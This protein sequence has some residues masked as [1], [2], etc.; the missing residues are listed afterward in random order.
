MVSQSE[1]VDAPPWRPEHCIGGH[2]SLDLVNT[3]SH[4]RDPS[5]AIDRMDRVEKIAFWCVYQ[6]LLSDRDA[7]AL[8]RF[9]RARGVEAALVASVN[10]LR[11]AAAEI[12]DAVAS[13][14]ELPSSALAEVLSA[15]ADI[16]VA[17]L[18]I[19]DDYRE[20]PRLLVR[21]IAVEAVVASMGLL[22]LDGVFR[23]PRVRVRSCPR[24]GWLFCDSSKGGRRR[25][26]SMKDC[27]NREKVSRHYQSRRG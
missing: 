7:Q 23:L 17:L 2:P 20:L 24:C 16:R 9:C 27:G 26:C 18:D 15:S 12:F 11:N 14:K 21:D 13:Q 3:I 1:L 8:I 10:A 6:G 19:P 5:L 25:W 22:V 4:R